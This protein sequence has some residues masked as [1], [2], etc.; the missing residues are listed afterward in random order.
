M[1]VL[2]SGGSSFTGY[3]FAKELSGRGH[4]VLAAVRGDMNAYS[5][6]R[7]RRVEALGSIAQIVEHAPFGSEVWMEAVAQADMVCHHAACV[8]DYRSEAFEVPKAL[9][10]N[11]A[12]GAEMVR[13]M[14]L[15]GSKGLIVTGSVFEADEGAGQLPL[16]AFSP[17]GLS[18]TFSFKVFEY[19]CAQAGLPLGKF[20]IPNPFGPFE[21]PRFTAFLMRSWRN[22]ECPGVNTPLYVRDNIHVDLLA[23]AYADFVERL[24]K[25]GGMLRTAP[26]GYVENQGAF[27]SRFAR[28]MSVRLDLPC[29]LTIGTQVDFAEP[30]VRIGTDPAA[31]TQSDWSESRSWD[32]LAAYYSL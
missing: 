22:G 14:V 4:T 16:R 26:S 3:W 10:Q 20:V 17:Y 2:L 19:W 7:K 32:D 28:E 11:T 31:P 24:A 8:D 1:K 5:N 23:L 15:N 29:P 30:L 6:V 25:D 18:K 27:A 9:A 12:N 13:Q 21:E